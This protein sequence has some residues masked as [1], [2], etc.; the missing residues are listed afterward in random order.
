MC[1]LLYF[2][3][4]TKLNK[5]SSSTFI[6][7]PTPAEACREKESASTPEILNPLVPLG[8]CGTQ[9]LKLKYDKFPVYF[10]EKF[11]LHYFCNTLKC[12]SKHSNQAKKAKFDQLAIGIQGAN[13]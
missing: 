8:C 2:Y 10:L 12:I 5:Q 13:T 4:N 6:W 7:Y 3:F 11:P 1:T 9:I